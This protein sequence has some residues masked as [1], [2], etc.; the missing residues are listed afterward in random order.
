MTRSFDFQMGLKDN[1]LIK[2]DLQCYI[3]KLFYFYFQKKWI[4]YN[5][6]DHNIYL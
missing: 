1:A 2:I 4:I 5:T 6:M 3:F